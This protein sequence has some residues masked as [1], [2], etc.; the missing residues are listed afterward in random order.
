MGMS[1]YQALIYILTYPDLTA[2]GWADGVGNRYPE[3]WADEHWA[4]FGEKEQRQYPTD[5]Y[6]ASLLRF[7]RWGTPDPITERI[8]RT[9]NWWAA[10]KTVEELRAMY[11]Q[12]KHIDLV[13]IAHERQQAADAEWLAKVSGQ[14]WYFPLLNIRQGWQKVGGTYVNPRNDA[15]KQYGT[16][17]VVQYAIDQ[18]IAPGADATVKPAEDARALDLSPMPG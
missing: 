8:V 10:Q 13:L 1:R 2:L 18:G 5:D 17:D 11:D 15:I 9:L 7:R 12:Y 4:N 14:P 6:M 3:H 16:W